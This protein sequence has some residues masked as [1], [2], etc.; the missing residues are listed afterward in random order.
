MVIEP[1]LWQGCKVLVTG[2]TGFKGS[3]LCLW[4]KQ[5]GAEVLGYSLDPPGRPNMFEVASVA[6]SVEHDVR[7]DIRNLP[8]FSRIFDEFK[9]DLTVHMAAQSLVQESYMQPVDTMTTNVIGTL[10][11]MEVVRLSNRSQAVLNVT[12][13][14]CYQ[15]NNSGYAFKETDRLGGEDPYACSKAC[16][17]LVSHAYASSYFGQP[18][19]PVFVANVR[20]GNVI[21]GGDWGK[22]RLIPDLINALLA[23]QP[24]KIR[25]PGYTR[26]WQHVLDALCGYLLLGQRLLLKQHDAVGDWNFGPDASSAIGV[27]DVVDRIMQLWGS[28]DEWQ[29]DDARHPVEAEKLVLDA[30][31]ASAQLQWSPVLTNDDIFRWT[32][33]WYRAWADKADMRAHSLMQIQHFQERVSG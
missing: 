12:S 3:W 28:K 7:D 31:K 17:E 29:M 15:N 26:P 24:P 33:D 4:L 14:K 21:G 11:V 32:V 20:A 1:T 23:N 25:N 16:A 18:E 30:S 10:H 6:E 19:N 8:A 2:H 13:D 9:P 5:L 22:N 27:A